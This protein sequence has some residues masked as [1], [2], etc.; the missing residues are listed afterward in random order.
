VYS[1]DRVCFYLTC[2]K[3]NIPLL[4]RWRVKLHLVPR[5]RMSGATSLVP[6]CDFRAWTEATL[7][8]LCQVVY[9]KVKKKPH[10]KAKKKFLAKYMFILYQHMHK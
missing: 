1:V 5:L 4:Y 6:L 9:H 7:P 8:F 10:F 2:S 3:S